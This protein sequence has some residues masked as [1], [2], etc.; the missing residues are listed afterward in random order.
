MM[1]KILVRPGTKLLTPGKISS[2]LVKNIPSSTPYVPPTKNDWEILFQSMF[3]EYLNPP[4]Y[5]DPQ[6]PI[7]IAPEHDVSTVIS[8]GVEEV[9]YDIEVAHM[10][11]NPSSGSCYDYY[12]EVDIQVEKSK[13]DKDPQEKAVDPIRYCGMIG[14][15]MYLT[16]SRPNLVFVVCMCAW[17]QTKPTKKHLHA[18]LQMLTMRVAKIP[19]K[20]RLE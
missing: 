9:D 8:L 18:L 20:V 14:T 17:Y 15:L 3:D 7:V 2:G 4:P 13:L 11:N 1:M 19:E 12:L 16:S 6:V 5:V 10:D